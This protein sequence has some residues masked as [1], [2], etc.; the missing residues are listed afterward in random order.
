MPV[1]NLTYAS[2][3]SLGIPSQA[4][5]NFLEDMQTYR[6]PLHS[7]LVLRHGKVAA[8][9]YCAPFDADRKHRMYSSTFLPVSFSTMPASTTV[10][11][12]S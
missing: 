12:V 2:P 6:I 10:A 4:I 3:E 1:N 8:E 7:Y 5:I 9:G 11:L